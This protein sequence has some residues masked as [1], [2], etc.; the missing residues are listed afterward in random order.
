MK[1]EK[2]RNIFLGFTPQSLA[3]LLLVSL[4]MLADGDFVSVSISM[5]VMALARRSRR[6]HGELMSNATWP[7]INSDRKKTS[8]SPSA[9]LER[10][11]DNRPWEKCQT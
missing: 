5:S 1:G 6:I 11:R 4:R 8:F 10:M 7:H 3:M 2:T 9:Q